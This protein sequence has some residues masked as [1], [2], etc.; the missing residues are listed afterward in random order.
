[1]N[2]SASGGRFAHNGPLRGQEVDIWQNAWFFS[3]IHHSAFSIVMLTLTPVLVVVKA[4]R[5]WQNVIL[6]AINAL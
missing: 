6:Y 1:M 2:K 3:L 4:M 5:I